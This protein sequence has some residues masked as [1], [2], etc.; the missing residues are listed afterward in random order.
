MLSILSTKELHSEPTFTCGF[1]RSWQ[2]LKEDVEG[3]LFA[4]LN[5]STGLSLHDRISF[6]EAVHD[7]SRSRFL[8]RQ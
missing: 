4:A 7:K 3:A 8:R 2:K 6:K 1:G 5:T